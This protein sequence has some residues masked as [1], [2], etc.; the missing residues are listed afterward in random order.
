MGWNIQEWHAVEMDE[1]AR[2]VAKALYPAVEHGGTDVLSFKLEQ[3][4]DVVL[5]GPPCQPWSRAGRHKAKGY[6]DPRSG[7]FSA[8]GRI[9]REAVRRNANTA[10]MVENVLVAKHLKD[11]EH[12]QEDEFGAEF[13][14]VNAADLGAPQ[15]RPRRVASN[16]MDLRELRQKPP[17]D[18]NAVLEAHGC[19]VE[20]RVVPCVMASGPN[21]HAPLKVWDLSVR[22]NRDAT[23]G[24]AAKLQGYQYDT[25]TAG[26]K[27][28]VT[29]MKQYE[30]VGNKF[31]Y[32][33][34]RSI[35]AEMEPRGTVRS[36]VVMAAARDGQEVSKLEKELGSLV[37]DDL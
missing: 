20:A 5:A 4:Y 23:P 16:V 6:G 1:T 10:F 3:D 11:E 34:V 28:P 8:A 29:E 32:E 27:V 35:F 13:V 18:P 21:T 30:L 26:G 7:A 37:G 33:L 22:R 24:E 15:R 2:A 31:H 12:R 17:V 14:V 19:V 9:T 25:A 36:G